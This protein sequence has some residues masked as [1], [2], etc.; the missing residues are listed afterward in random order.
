MKNTLETRL[1]IFVALAVIAAV[2]ILEVI[3]GIE[4]FKPGENIQVKILKLDREKEKISLGFKQLQPD[5]WSTV[6]E[7]YPVDSKVNGKISSVTVPPSGE[8]PVAS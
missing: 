5:P 3:G 2:L 4:M 6:V 7:V 8:N 1:G